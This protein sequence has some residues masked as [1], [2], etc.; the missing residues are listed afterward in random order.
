MSIRASVSSSDASFAGSLQVIV[1]INR[2]YDRY[3]QYSKLVIPIEGGDRPG[4]DLTC[5]SIRTRDDRD[6]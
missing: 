2:K 4:I 3:F 6:L 1:I 5:Q